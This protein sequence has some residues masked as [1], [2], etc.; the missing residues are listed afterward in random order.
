MYVFLN[1]VIDIAAGENRNLVLKDDGSVVTWGWNGIPTYNNWVFK[2]VP[3]NVNNVI[4][5]E[6][7]ENGLNA[8]LKSDGDIVCWGYDHNNG[9]FSIPSINPINT[10]V[11][12]CTDPTAINYN[13]IANN[14][15][16]CIYPIYGCTII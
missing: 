6:C 1:N 14:N 13:F 4:A 7:R 2:L 9:H 15:Q 5:I 3:S 8:V 11:C 10:N 16:N 12:G